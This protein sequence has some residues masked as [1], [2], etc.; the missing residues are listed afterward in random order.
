[1]RLHRSFEQ[2]FYQSLAHILALGEDEVRG[3][4]VHTIRV[5]H[6]GHTAVGQALEDAN[7]GRLTNTT[8]G[9]H[10]LTVGQVDVLAQPAEE[11]IRI[12]GFLSEAFDGLGVHGNT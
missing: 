1:M 4:G 9:V 8:Y 7:D 2:H 12:L 10:L 3:D 5:L 11:F 6:L